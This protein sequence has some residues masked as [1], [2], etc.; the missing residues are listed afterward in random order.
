MRLL[1]RFLLS[2]HISLW[3]YGLIAFPLAIIPSIGLLIVARCL[4]SA[5]G[6]DVN[7]FAPP[8]RSASFG[9][10]L[11]IVVF[12]PLVETVL[13]AGVLRV[14]SLTSS[15]AMFVAMA[16]AVIWGGVHAAF[17][18]TWFFG[19]VWSFFIFSCAYLGWRPVSFKAAFLAAWIP[20]VLINLT[21]MSI[22]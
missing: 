1:A 17:G 18:L 15:R 22:V 14:L 13:L 5:A 9:E 10:F 16:S 11:G 7:F 3:K 20:H 21:A 4:L 6:V 19:T 2:P 12:A 8:E